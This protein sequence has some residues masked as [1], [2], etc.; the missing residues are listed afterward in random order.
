MTFLPLVHTEEITNRATG[1]DPG[2]C[3]GAEAVT[4]PG[5]GHVPVPVA[6]VR[7]AVLAES[8]VVVEPGGVD[9]V[10]AE[11]R[12]NYA[13]GEGRGGGACQAAIVRQPRPVEVTSNRWRGP[14][15]AGINS[16]PSTPT[17]LFR[18]SSARA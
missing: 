14:V 3:R 7:V 16:V 8:S 5:P 18:L 1:A 10:E 2:F 17:L 9:L 15:V 4:L 12:P 11:G 6:V 13:T